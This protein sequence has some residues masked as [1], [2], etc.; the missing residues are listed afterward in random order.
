MR[1]PARRLLRWATLLLF[2]EKIVGFQ[3]R[4]GGKPPGAVP[5]KTAKCHSDLRYSLHTWQR[6][7]RV[8]SERR[9]MRTWYW[10]SGYVRSRYCQPF[11][12][13]D[14]AGRVTLVIGDSAYQIIA[15]TINADE[16]IPRAITR[17]PTS[18][19]THIMALPQRVGGS[20]LTWRFTASHS[21]IGRLAARLFS[22]A[23]RDCFQRPRPTIPTP[24]IDLTGFRRFFGAPLGI[25]KYS[26]EIAL[27]IRGW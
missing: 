8:N 25:E 27:V 6:K 20:A 14:A 1:I 9:G 15:I 22:T 26:A 10:T 4:A 18:R 3:M 24:P 17:S 7:G 21:K 23:A 19:S 12:S 13:Y 5:G 11:R 16:R 2:L